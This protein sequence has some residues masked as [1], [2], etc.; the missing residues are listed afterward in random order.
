ME[1]VLLSSPHCA[2]DRFKFI[3]E[4]EEINTAGIHKWG[5]KKSPKVGIV[6]KTSE[7]RGRL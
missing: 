6:G 3:C 4:R 5:K 2:Y 7:K 1:E